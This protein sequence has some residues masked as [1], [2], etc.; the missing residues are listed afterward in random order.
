MDIV[1]YEPWLEK[2][3]PLPLLYAV[4]ILMV[5]LMAADGRREPLALSLGVHRSF[6]KSQSV[7]CHY[8]NIFGQLLW[9]SGGAASHQSPWYVGIGETS[10][11]ANL[12][13]WG[14]KRGKRWTP[15]PTP[16]KEN[17]NSCTPVYLQA[18]LH[19][20]CSLTNTN[21]HKAC[22]AA[23][24]LSDNRSG[25]GRRESHNPFPAVEI[26]SRNTKTIR[27]YD[28]V[29]FCCSGVKPRACLLARHKN[30]FPKVSI[31]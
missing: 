28:Y 20:K 14:R 11:A 29:P 5:F 9:R 1:F 4:V 16:P 7:L 25:S 2:S 26:T 31:Q 13:E 3:P 15:T 30:V 23:T 18:S 21:T 27:S 22:G 10:G 6:N 8:I 24:P 17:K 12:T 19:N